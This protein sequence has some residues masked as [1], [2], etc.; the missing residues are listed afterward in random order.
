MGTLCVNTQA[1][2]CYLCQRLSLPQEEKFSP[3]HFLFLRPNG[4]M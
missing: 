4:S 2:F 1:A 3:E